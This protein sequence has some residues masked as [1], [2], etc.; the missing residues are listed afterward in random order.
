MNG[1]M[2]STNKGNTIVIHV[3]VILKM[4]TEKLSGELPK[5]YNIYS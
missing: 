4:V 2:N 3:Y 1:S 5:D